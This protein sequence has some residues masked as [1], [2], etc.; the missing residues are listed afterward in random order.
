MTHVSPSFLGGWDLLG[1]WVLLGQGFDLDMTF[2]VIPVT[3]GGT[4]LL[5]LLL[6]LHRD[7]IKNLYIP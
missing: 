3:L 6:L 2:S 7:F 4:L 5:L 1:I